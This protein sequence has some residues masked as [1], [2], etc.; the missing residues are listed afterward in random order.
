MS[1]IWHSWPL[2]PLWEH[3]TCASGTLHSWFSYLTDHPFSVSLAGSFSSPYSPHCWNV[4]LLSPW[5][6]LFTSLTPLVISSRLK[7][8]NVVHVP[9]FPNSTYLANWLPDISTWKSSAHLKVN[10]T[11]AKLLI[12]HPAPQSLLHCSFLTVVDGILPFK[13]LRPKSWSPW[14]PS[15]S[16]SSHPTSGN[17]AGMT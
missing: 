6:S 16:H 5:S 4:P 17:H 13:P 9:L 8:L 7:V 15:I 12:C 1:A 2:L 3:S 14:L 10:M 11:Q